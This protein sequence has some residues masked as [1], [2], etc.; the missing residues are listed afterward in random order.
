MNSNVGRAFRVRVPGA[1]VIVDCGAVAS[2][3]TVTD[4]GA[5]TLPA[6]SVA[7]TVYVCVP[8][9]TGCSTC[10]HAPSEV[11]SASLSSP[12]AIVTSAPA[13]AV[14]DR[15]TVRLFCGECTGSITGAAGAVVSTGTP[16]SGA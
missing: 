16:L 6:A 1:T 5:D 13:S 3:R 11:T 15:L 2:T 7:V 10:P 8:S 9:A 4:A 14:P 12:S